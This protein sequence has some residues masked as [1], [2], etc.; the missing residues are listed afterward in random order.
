MKLRDVLRRSV[1]TIEFVTFDAKVCEMFPP[2]PARQAA[3][4]W[5]QKMGSAVEERRFPNL[6]L[7][8]ELTAKSCPGIA[9]YLAQGYVIPL[10]ADYL[11]TATEEGF[12]CETAYR[13]EDHVFNFSSAQMAGFKSKMGDDG[14]HF[15]KINVPWFVRTSP[16]WSVL[17]L[18]PW[19]HQEKRCTVIPGLVESDR[20]G[21]MNFTSVWHV[22]VGEAALLRAGMPI[23]H[24]VPIRR[25][26][27]RGRVVA[28]EKAYDEMKGRGIDAVSAYRLAPGAYREHARRP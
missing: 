21:A 15:L 27:I 18:E 14:K 2:V 6:R 19:F 7:S 10:W 20:L 12:V 26:R 4:D 22:P 16:G 17:L 3:P 1:P 13:E 5:F 25:G 11:V 9:D 23:L 28:D 8:G 24:V